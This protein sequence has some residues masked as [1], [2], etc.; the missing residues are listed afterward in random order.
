MLLDPD[1]SACLCERY[2]KR[3]FDAHSVCRSD[4]PISTMFR[5]TPLPLSERSNIVS[6]CLYSQVT[7]ACETSPADDILEKILLDLARFGSLQIVSLDTQVNSQ[8]NKYYEF[9]LFALY[10]TRC[11]FL[12]RNL[13]LVDKTIKRR[14]QRADLLIT[15]NF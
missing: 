6:V 9:E 12:P 15:F 1:V 4:Q 10:L 5:S 14:L 8:R 2:A 11:E 13:E 7:L 3:N